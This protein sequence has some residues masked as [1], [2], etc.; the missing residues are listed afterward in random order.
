M[1]AGMRKKQD[2]IITANREAC[3]AASIGLAMPQRRCRY[4]TGLRVLNSMIL[5]TTAVRNRSVNGIPSTEYMIQ[6]ALPPSDRGTV[7]PYP[8]KQVKL[9][10]GSHL[11][12]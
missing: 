10:V 9:L 1:M 11:G 4:S 7:W 6:K 3:M 12:F 2:T 5:C 8:A